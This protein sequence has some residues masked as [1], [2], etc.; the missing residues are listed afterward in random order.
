MPTTNGLDASFELTK[1]AIA[2]KA[3]SIDF[4]MR[5]YSHNA[6]KKPVPGGS[7]RLVRRRPGN[8][9]RMGNLRHP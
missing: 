5:Y 6:T 2:L 8:R 9:R 3:Q 7:P 4:V 1:H